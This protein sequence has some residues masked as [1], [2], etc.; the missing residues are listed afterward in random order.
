[1]ANAVYPFGKDQLLGVKD[2]T[3]NTF[4][5]F[6]MNSS[7]TYSSTHSYWSAISSLSLAVTSQSLGTTT[8]T[9]GKWTTPA[10][11]F[12]TVAS[13]S[14]C[15]FVIIC[16]SVNA[17]QSPLILYADTFSTGAGPIATNGGTITIGPDVS[18]GWFT[19]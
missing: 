18:L 15:N 7:Y 8:L 5:A 1:M 17:S 3:A 2:L 13:G 10:V 14:S 19:M 6:L 11:S 9:N 4:G 12:G 16:S